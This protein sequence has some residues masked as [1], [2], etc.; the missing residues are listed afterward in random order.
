MES[1]NNSAPLSPR[2]RKLALLIILVSFLT[3]FIVI[4]FAVYAALR[5]WVPRRTIKIKDV[6]VHHLCLGIALLSY[7]G[8]Y[9]L[10]WR[11]VNRLLYRT[12][13]IYGVALSLT[14]DEFA[15]WLHL[16]NNYWH[17]LN[18]VAMGALLLIFLNLIFFNAFWRNLGTKIPFL[19]RK[20]VD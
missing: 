10:L 17:P 15:M 2:D 14:F 6:H 1:M 9:A 4:R 13:I 7:V 16:D 8:I 11:P 19:R 12:Y 3:T 18:F 5:G 20:L